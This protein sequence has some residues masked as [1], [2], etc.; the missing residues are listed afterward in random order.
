MALVLQSNT[1]NRVKASS[2]LNGGAE[3]KVNKQTKICSSVS[4]VVSPSYLSMY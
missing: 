3:D 4:S 1:V 2:T